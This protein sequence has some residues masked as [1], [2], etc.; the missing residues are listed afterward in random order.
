MKLTIA[1]VGASVV[2][3]DETISFPV[4]DSHGR[5][6]TIE[7]KPQAQ[8]HL[9]LPLL[10]SPPVESGTKPR[11]VL[12]VAAV[13]LSVTNQA[14][15][16]LSLYLRREAAIHAVLELVLFESLKSQVNSLNIPR[17]SKH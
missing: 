7:L 16:G 9:L 2:L 17:Q 1:S 4:K 6:H 8:E 11:R 12:Q 10:A 5:A 15:V 14:R 3:P 13:Q